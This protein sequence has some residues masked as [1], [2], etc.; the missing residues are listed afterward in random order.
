MSSYS[1]ERNESLMHRYLSDIITNKLND[2]ALGFVTVTAVKIT[3]DYS[4]A[5]VFVS[6]IGDGDPQPKLLIL[7]KAKGLIRHELSQR[8][9]IRKM[10]ELKFKHDDT[11]EKARRLDEI[12]KKIK[13]E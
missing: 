7:E 13:D 4:Y 5:T 1:R 10:P 2:R 9:S 11:L 3:R 8:M 6:F 12:F